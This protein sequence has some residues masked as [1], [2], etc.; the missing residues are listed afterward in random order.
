M[1]TSVTVKKE[2]RGPHRRDE[3]LSNGEKGRERSS[4]P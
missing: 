3:D 4:S 2:E 1:K